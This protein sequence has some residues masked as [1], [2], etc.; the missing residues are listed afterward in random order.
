MS[1]AA[2][3]KGCWDRGVAAGLVATLAAG[4]A[5]V[6]AEAPQG[7]YEPIL[8][9]AHEE[10]AEQAPTQVASRIMPAV[11]D[12]S[13]FNLTQL[14]GEHPLMPALRVAKESLEYIDKNIP[15]YQ[16]M[17]YKQE[18]IDGELQGQEVAFVQVRHQPF[19][20]HMFFLAPNKGRECLF[21]EGPAGTDG[22]LL[23]RDSGM[24]RRLGVVKLDPNGRFA[25]AGQKYPIT[26]LGVRNLTA[27][28]VDVATKDVQYG[29]CEVTTR[30][31][32]LGVKG[33][34]K[35]ACTVLS[36]VHPNPRKTFRFHK[37]EVWMDNEL[38]VPIR[39]AAYLWP[40][41]PGGEAPLEEAYTY[42]KFQVIDNFADSY[43]SQSNPE[44]FRD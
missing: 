20:V 27:E 7:T 16:A 6:R 28:L 31:D 39:Y 17:M 38:R 35:R 40:A 26:K 11:S 15:G 44:I 8:R 4:S 22:N 10:P 21:A 34:D 29:E 13:P 23:A 33:G 41:Q 12:Q 24:R 36:V 42:L 9:V 5:A 25:M 19:S 2:R 3:L 43:F 18:R 32:V 37:A 14:P 1:I 30:Q